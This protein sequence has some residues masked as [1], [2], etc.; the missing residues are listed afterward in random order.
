[1]EAI[2]YQ[3]RPPHF[4]GYI[5]FKNRQRFSSV[6]KMV[7]RAEFTCAKEH[8]QKIATIIQ[9]RMFFFEESECLP[10]TERINAPYKFAVEKTEIGQFFAIKIH[11][12]GCISA[13]KVC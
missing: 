9:K 13:I 12:Q 11:T 10:T 2:I 7:T 6:Q 5:V 1:M 8:L 3:G 4:Q